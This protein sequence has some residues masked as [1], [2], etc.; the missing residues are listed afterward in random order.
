[1]CKGIE[2]SHRI[3]SFTEL[4]TEARDT[5]IVDSFFIHSLVKEI[6]KL[7]P[8]NSSDTFDIRS[9]AVLH[10]KQGKPIT[11]LFGESFGIV[12]DGKK[13]KDQESIFKLINDKIYSTQPYEYWYP[14]EESRSLYRFINSIDETKGASD[15]SYV[16]F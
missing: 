13:M 5:V 10:R 16:H 4:K 3:S 9:G 14:D 2:F 1:M 6:N 12:Y 7:V 8:E 15:S 11:I